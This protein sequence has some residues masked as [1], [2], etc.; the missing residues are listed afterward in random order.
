VPSP[1]LIALR[2]L[3]KT[4]DGSAAAKPVIASLDLEVEEGEFVVLLGRSGSGKSTVLNLI[5]GLDSPSAGSV[6]ING[7]ELST[8]SDTERTL[9]RRRHIGFIFQAY[10]LIPTLTV[11]ENL[12]LPLEINQ[13]DPADAQTRITEVLDALN[14]G[15]KIDRFPEELS[16]GEQQRVAIARAMVHDPTVILADEPTGNLD[17]E[18]GQQV[19]ALLDQVTRSRG[20]TLIMATHSM[21]VVGIAD[22]ILTIRE[23]RLIEAETR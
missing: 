5:A 18:T 21:E 3:S 17:L 4:Y 15:E 11:R 6:L 14:I 22:R 20:K 16:G 8:L 7:A 1:P 23:G 19:L 13:I 9:F 2:G 12:S 10:S